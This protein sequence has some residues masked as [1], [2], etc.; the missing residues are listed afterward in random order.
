MSPSVAS[1]AGARSTAMDSVSLGGVSRHVGWIASR[2]HGD[3]RGFCRSQNDLMLNEVQ[4]S[5]DCCRAGTDLK[6]TIQEARDTIE[7]ALAG[8]K[9]HQMQLP[10]ELPLME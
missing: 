2:A 7:V 4:A 9:S 5:I 3:T 1:Q 8:R 6:P 10:V